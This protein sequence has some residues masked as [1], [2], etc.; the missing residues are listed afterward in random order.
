MTIL[1][2]CGALF[3]A[4]IYVKCPELYRNIFR[5]GAIRSI[6]LSRSYRAVSFDRFNVID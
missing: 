3:T 1:R 2:D 5:V 4:C 6:N